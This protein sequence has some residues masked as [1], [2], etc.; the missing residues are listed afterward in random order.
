MTSL[1]LVAFCRIQSELCD[2]AGIPSHAGMQSFLTQTQTFS[3]SQAIAAPES[4]GYASSD[5]HIDDSARRRTTV[6]L[7]E[8]PVNTRNQSSCTHQAQQA[9]QG[10]D[11]GAKGTGRAQLWGPK[12]QQLTSSSRGSQERKA[13]SRCMLKHRPRSD[14][15]A[16]LASG[17]S[18]VSRHTVGQRLAASG[19]GSK[20]ATKGQAE[21]FP[22]DVLQQGGKLTQRGSMNDASHAGHQGLKQAQQPSGITKQVP[23]ATHSGRGRKL[24]STTS[25]RRKALLKALVRTTP[26]RAPSMPP[27]D[28]TQS[29]GSGITAQL[30]H[31]HEHQ[32][33]C[34]TASHSSVSA[35]A[36]GSWHHQDSENQAH[37]TAA[38]EDFLIGSQPNLALSLGIGSDAFADEA[39]ADACN[40][41]P[42]HGSTIGQVHDCWHAQAFVK[43]HVGSVETRAV[44]RSLLFQQ[45]FC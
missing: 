2:I 18:V 13:D 12:R 27:D 25:G 38:P 5:G 1:I 32:P 10:S 21:P 30:G 33:L 31:A 9:R 44:R 34:K 36:K 37:N 41:L 14:N 43:E 4:Q 20:Q 35:D 15:D 8:I 3:S 24:S 11:S 23:A 29:T 22:A 19:T 17:S 7:L 26:T 39:I 6:P 40:A 16:G 42:E 45:D 28:E